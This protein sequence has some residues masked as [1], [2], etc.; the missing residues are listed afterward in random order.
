MSNEAKVFEWFIEPRNSQ[1]NEAIA[2]YLNLT[3]L[4]VDLVPGLEDDKGKKHDCFRVPY[5]VIN[6]FIK[7]THSFIKFRI[8]NRDKNFGPIK[9][10]TLLGKK[11]SKKAREAR[12]ALKKL[13]K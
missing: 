4:R 5:S 1:T 13:G 10:F 3:A 11:P 8:W 2:D 6:V 12:K 7:K 9:A